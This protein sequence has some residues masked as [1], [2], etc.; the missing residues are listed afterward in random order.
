MAGLAPPLLLALFGAWCGTFAWGASSPAGAVAVIVLLGALS[1]FGASWRDPLRLGDVGRLLPLALWITVAASAWASPV[2]RAGWMAV[3]LLPAFLGLPGTVERCWRREVDRRRGLRALAIVVTGISLWAL[4]DWLIL[5]TPRPSMP[6]GH[7]NLLAAW[8]VILLPLSVLPAREEGRWRLTGLAAGALAACAIIASRSLA[9]LAGLAME[10][11]IGFGGRARPRWRRWWAV[12]LA[13]V[14]LL[15]LVQLPRVAR[16]VAGKDPSAQARA[17]YWAAGVKGFSARPLLGWGPGAAAWTSATFLDPTPGVNPWGE[18]VGELHSLPLQVGYELGL[19]GI[20][21]A[22]GLTVLF[23]IRR[24]LEREEG[25]DPGLLGSGLL[26]LGG[27]AVASL[28]SGA[29]AV[30]ALPLAAAVAAGAA[31]AGSGRGKTRPDSRGPLWIYAAA[32][33]LALLRPE[34]ARWHYDRAAAADAAGRHTEAEAALESA[35]RSDPAF[36]LYPMRLALLRDR[37]TGARAEA[38]QLA[39]EAA[40]RGGAVPS[41]WLVA[42]ILGAAAGRPWG[43]GAL[44]NACAL[45]PLNPFPPFYRMLASPAESAAPLYGAHALLA[46][47]HLAAASFFERHPE[48]LQRSL[49]AVRPWPGVDAGWKETLLAA[50]Q[51]NGQRGPSSKI[52]LL[53]D[54]EPETSLSLSLFRRSRWPARWPLI[55]V[56]QEAVDR[57]GL[58]AALSWRGTS[59]A[60]VRAVPCLQRSTRERM[61]LTR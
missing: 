18:S 29:L 17:S 7:H 40:E 27:G 23:F 49:A 11:L 14:F 19:T 37:R 39:L 44:E 52:E 54:A 10:A 46:E 13:L 5:G 51:T 34:L 43:A 59:P 42:G 12:L 31:L 21:L 38:S 25:R 28:G 2:P 20:L 35:M 56:R 6:L 58:P 16:I 9:G 60:A 53:I 48:L 41:L 30:T 22:L 33:L 1:V 45:D 61:P 50:A 57:L 26:G 3:V 55:Q 36:P 47:P 32:A 4:L 15:S 8:L 24:I